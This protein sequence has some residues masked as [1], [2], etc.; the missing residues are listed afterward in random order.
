MPTLNWIGKKAV[1]RHDREIPF[2]LLKAN[3]ELSVG[4]P[5]SDHLLVQGDNLHALKALLPRYA[6]EVKC[7]YIDPPYNT[8]NEGWKYND[9]VNGP[10]MKAW[11]DHIVGQ[12]GEDL[13]RHDKWLCM[14]Y[15]RLQLLHRFLRQDG[16]IFVSIDDNEL[17]NLLYLCDAIFGPTNRLAVF[18]WVRKKKG[19]HLDHHARKITEYVLCYARNR[20]QCGELFG[21]QA[22]TDKAQPLVKRT[23]K[24]KTLY[25]ASGVVST[26]LE[27][28]AYPAGQRG[29][30]GTAL[31]FENAFQVADGRI[32]DAFEVVGRFV[33]TQTTL[34]EELRKGTAVTLSKKFGFNAMRW[35]QA[36]K[37]KRPPTL[38]N[39]DLGIGTNED[40]SEELA[41]IFGAERGTIFPFPKP[42][43][44][45]RFLVNAVTHND[46]SAIVMDSFAG[47]GTTGHAV[48]ELNRE[49]E[50]NRRFLLVELDAEI[51][52]GVTRERLARVIDGYEVSSGPERG[53]RVDGLGGGFRY[54][55]L[56]LPL[57]D[58]LGSIR[59]SVK[60]GDLAAHVY[61]CETGR[62]L[63]RLNGRKS[64]LVG[65]HDGTAVYLLFNGVLEDFSKEGGNILTPSILAALP[66]HDGPKVIYAAGCKVTQSRLAREHVLF[67]QTP[68]QIK[69]Y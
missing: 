62:P 3:S 56:D 13:S 7:I 25:F 40:A 14:M 42:V 50:G 34:D 44:L 15:P 51:A 30:E 5:G 16:V 20:N 53:T 37:T 21:E 12:E 19:S 46:K 29:K 17:G 67:R 63:R 39:S 57:F 8:G 6:G 65:V 60:F 9:A 28:G 61:F 52:R 69:T 11:L 55:E 24:P 49:D 48:M 4:G 10:E 31:N 26:T 58:D 41:R 23:N 38:L 66:P 54:C 64:P 47:S 18:T 36:D 43:S 2:R 22:Y 1:L 32:I 45:I 59:T 35:D 33:W 27:D 68:Y